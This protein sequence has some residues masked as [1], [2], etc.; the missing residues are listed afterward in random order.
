MDFLQA[1]NA[2][3]YIAGHR[4]MVGSAITR[5][6]NA[7][8]F[9]NIVTRTSADLDLRTQAAVDAFF[10]AERPDYVFLAAAR[11]GGILA[12]DSY[13]ADFIYDNLLIEANIIHAAYV[14]RVNP[15]IA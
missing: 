7:A 3:V 14:Q 12:N 15:I 13:P 11:V 8:G 10:P 2:K 5:V 9:K 6:L 1:T 4:G